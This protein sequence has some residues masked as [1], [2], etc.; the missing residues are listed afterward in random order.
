MDIVMAYSPLS[1]KDAAL[2]EDREDRE[3]GEFAFPHPAF[4]ISHCAF[5]C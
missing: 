5:P 4:R 2:R 1:M 3:D